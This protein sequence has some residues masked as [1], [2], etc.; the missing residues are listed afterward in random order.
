MLT[1]AIGQ[2]EKS[3]PK[4]APVKDAKT[5]TGTPVKDVKTAAETPV[6]DVRE[7]PA[8]AVKAAPVKEDKEDKRSMSSVLYDEIERVIGGDNDNQFFCLTMPGQALN[9]ADYSYDYK[10]GGTKG[11]K[12]KRTSRALPTSCSTPAASR[13]RTTV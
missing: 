6:K 4:T 8:K 1:E 10:N 11:P 2:R 3:D 9:A 13:V 12:L 7:A 5:A